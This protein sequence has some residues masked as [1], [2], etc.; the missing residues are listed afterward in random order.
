MTCVVLLNL[1]EAL[2]EESSRRAQLIYA[3]NEGGE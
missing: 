3:L 1:A 2:P